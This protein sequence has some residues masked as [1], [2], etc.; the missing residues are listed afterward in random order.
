MSDDAGDGGTGGHGETVPAAGEQ[1]VSGSED[2]GDAPKGKGGAVPDGLHPGY[3]PP[4]LQELSSPGPSAQLGPLHGP[5]LSTER[6]PDGAQEIPGWEETVAGEAVMGT[7]TDGSTFC[8]STE[9]GT[10]GAT[11]RGE[12]KRLDLGVNV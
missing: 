8:G 11:V 12:T 3:G 9:R 1:V 2:L 4:S 5:G 7:N 10:E 6:S